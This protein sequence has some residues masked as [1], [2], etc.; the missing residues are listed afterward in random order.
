MIISCSKAI[1]II[2][3]LLL[4]GFDLSPI[5]CR[6]S[7]FCLGMYLNPTYLDNSKVHAG[8]LAAAA[9]VAG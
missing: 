7:A 8:N 9:G 5:E 4:T 6:Q 2:T 3:N 1:T